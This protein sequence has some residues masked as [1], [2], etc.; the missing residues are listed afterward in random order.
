MENN[1]KK[2]F[3]ANPKHQCC[4]PQRGEHGC[5]AN[6]KKNG[7]YYEYP[8][9]SHFTGKLL[10]I[11]KMVEIKLFLQTQSINI[12]YPN[13]ENLFAMPI[14]KIIVIVMS[15]QVCLISRMNFCL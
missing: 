14:T 9:L 10:I 15:I 6:N 12:M 2:A 11:R 13:V 8:S 5:H 4:V 7:D 3:P 1:G